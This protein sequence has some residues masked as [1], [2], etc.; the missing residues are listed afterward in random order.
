MHPAAEGN[1]E[2]T[3]AGGNED[4]PMALQELPSPR[5]PIEEDLTTARRPAAADA[6]DQRRS[7]AA[8]AADVQT[9]REDDGRGTTTTTTTT[10]SRVPNQ[11][12]LDT[13]TARRPRRPAADGREEPRARR[14]PP[15]Q[16]YALG[17]ATCTCTFYLDY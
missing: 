3:A 10:R 13:Q 5:R 11:A 1:E 12:E 14:E 15:C 7:A 4:E 2:A 8:P 17:R 6:L 16:C 9:A